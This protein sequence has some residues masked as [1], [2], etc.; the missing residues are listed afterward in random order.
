[1]GFFDVFIMAIKNLFKRK[2]RT[3]LTVLGVTIGTTAIVVL[4]SFGIAANMNFDRRLEA[5]GDTLNIEIFNWSNNWGPDGQLPPDVILNFDMIEYIQSWDGVEV[6]TPI[7]NFWRTQIVSQIGRRTNDRIWGGL[8]GILPEAMPYLPGFREL[9][10]GQLLQ[11][12]GS[13][14]QA[15]FCA[16]IPFH[17]MTQLE[18]DIYWQQH[19]GGGGF[20]RGFGS[21]GGSVQ[22]MSMTQAEPAGMIVVPSPG[23]PSP[24]GPGG[25]QDARSPLV[26]IFNDVVEISYDWRAFEPMTPPDPNPDPNVPIINIFRPR[27]VYEIQPVGTITTGWETRNAII[28]DIRTVMKLWNNWEDHEINQ[29]ST[30]VTET[31]FDA[32][33]FERAVV[34][35]TDIHSAESVFLRIEELGFTQVESP[36]G[37]L[38]ALREQSDS[39]Q[40]LLVV[41]GAVAMIVAFIGIANTMI[42][43]IYERT[44]EIGVMKVVGASLSDIGK[45]FL[46]EAAVIGAIGGLL[47]LAASFGLSHLLNNLDEGI[48]FLDALIPTGVEGYTSFIPMWLYGMAFAFSAVV[49]LVAGFLPALR[50]MR[51]SALTAI[52]TD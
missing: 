36:F 37:E 2:V 20:F 19:W 39:L 35:A 25:G 1:M 41:V 8:V 50:A 31:D 13:E 30:W 6:A 47:G 15:V 42:M 9:E 44:K 11:P 32:V 23:R 38:A 48:A 43:S 34:R 5:F 52:R 22:L 4:I 29:G 46:V 12:G 33:G 3:F 27:P 14:W 40:V 21:S 7:L 28:M 45:L 18:R 17:Y 16:E 51:V 10:Q 49:G 24:G 26:D